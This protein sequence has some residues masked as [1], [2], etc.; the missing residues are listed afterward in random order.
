MSLD[1]ASGIIMLMNEIVQLAEL[2]E[3]MIKLLPRRTS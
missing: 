2:T 3:I 1:L